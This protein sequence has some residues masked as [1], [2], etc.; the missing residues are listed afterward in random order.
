MWRIFDLRETAALNQVPSPMNPNHFI[1]QSCHSLRVRFCRNGVRF[2]EL[3]DADKKLV[4]LQTSG[5]QLHSTHY[6]PI[7]APYRT[8]Y[9]K[10]KQE[11][12]QAR[13]GESTTTVCFWD[14]APLG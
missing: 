3:L 4:P 5:I 12:Q 2:G 6:P 1:H 7:D 13:S 11:K 9:Y 14:A 8:R 10:Q